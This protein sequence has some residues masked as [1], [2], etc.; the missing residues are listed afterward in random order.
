[1]K[2]TVIKPSV[3]LVFQNFDKSIDV[4]KIDYAISKL[5]TFT[6]LEVLILNA[7]ILSKIS[8]RYCKIIF[9]ML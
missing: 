9:S 4:V 5:N 2:D 1:M 8:Q 6:N 3:Y 7:R